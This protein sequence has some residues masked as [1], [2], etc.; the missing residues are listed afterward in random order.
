MVVIPSRP[1]EKAE[2]QVSELLDLG[3]FAGFDAILD[4]SRAYEGYPPSEVRVSDDDSHP[5]ATGHRLLYERIYRELKGPSGA[6]ITLFPPPTPTNA[7]T[8]KETRNAP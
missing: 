6:A 1:E 7:S 5:N 2:S 3:K 4:L 8:D